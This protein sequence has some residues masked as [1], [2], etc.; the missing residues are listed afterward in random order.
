MPACRHVNG[1]LPPRGP[2]VKQGRLCASVSFNPAGWMCKED[3]TRARKENT[4][5]SWSRHFC[6][7]L[8]REGQKAVPVLYPD[9]QIFNLTINMTIKMPI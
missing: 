7:R 3:S 2:P 8:S 6:V 5:V 1:A 9:F 4:S